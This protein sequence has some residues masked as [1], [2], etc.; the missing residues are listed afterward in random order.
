MHPNSLRNLKRTAGPGRPPGLVSS[1]R[2]QTKNGDELV[3]FMLRVLRGKRLRGQR[4]TLR[5]RMEA[6]DWL[7]DRGWG[8]AVLASEMPAE[9]AAVHPGGSMVVKLTAEQA[10]VTRE[11][12]RQ[13]RTL[14]AA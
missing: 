12:L 5:H 7:A 3:R 8:K 4:P 10:E 11:I 9:V 6:A 14:G 13:T 2:R 1:I